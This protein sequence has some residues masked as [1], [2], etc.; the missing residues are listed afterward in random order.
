MIWVLRERGA[1]GTSEERS[2]G[3][4]NPLAEFQPSEDRCGPPDVGDD[5]AREKDFPITRRH[6]VVL[7]CTVSHVHGADEW[8][9]LYRK[10]QH[11]HPVPAA[12]R[13]LHHLVKDL[14]RLS[15][16]DIFKGLDAEPV[17]LRPVVEHD[18]TVA[19]GKR[20]SPHDGCAEEGTEVPHH[21]G[22]QH[23]VE[24]LDDEEVGGEAN[25]KNPQPFLDWLSGVVHTPPPL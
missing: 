23:V 21:A 19:D 10:N 3:L 5:E 18:G 11:N 4:P 20:Q 13:P 16:T 15:V 25:P 12:H 17:L 22:V 7:V 9:E 1:S 6:A 2:E 24:S 14:L 8:V